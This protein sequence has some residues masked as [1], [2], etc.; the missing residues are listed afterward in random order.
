M[1]G[2]FTL[3]RID[4]VVGFVCTSD[5]DAK[6]RDRVVQLLHQKDSDLDVVRKILKGGVAA[7]LVLIVCV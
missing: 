5:A 1:Q 2:L 6:M 7:R 3:Q 4:F